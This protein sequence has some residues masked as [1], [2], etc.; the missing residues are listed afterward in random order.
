MSNSHD[1]H[2]NATI[3]EKLPK[4]SIGLAV[5]NGERYLDEAIRSILAQTFVDFELIISDNASTDRTEE[6]CKTYKAKDARIRYHR[7]ETNIG[8]ANNENLTF[9]LSRGKYFRWAAHDDVCGPD[10]FKRLVQVLDEHPDVV[11]ALSSIMNIDEN[12]DPIGVVK[13]S[14]ATSGTPSQRFRS[15]TN[16]NHDCEATYGLIRS[17]IMR[18]TDLERN[19]TDSDRTFLCQ[20]SL[21][22]KFYL[23]DE[24][25]FFR[26]IHPHAS[27]QVYSDWRERMD[28]F[29][30]SSENQIT[31]PY[32]SQLIHYLSVIT[33]AP[34]GVGEKIRCYVHMFSEWLIEWRR[35][36]RLGRDILLAIKKIWVIY[37]FPSRMKQK[38]VN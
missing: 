6:I 32:W 24:V 30:K 1:L 10:L 19:Y 4:V 35:W 26:R 11:L 25:L 2:P 14:N 18:Q 13:R 38:Q 3:N 21:F 5:Y 31:M 33:R 22:G 8:G 15:L 9:K 29:G 34:I 36:G 28:W 37:L 23:V 27:T 16:F 7:N 17:D 12:G 20:L